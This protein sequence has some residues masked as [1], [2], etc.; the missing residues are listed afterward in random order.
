MGQI[1][2][3][4]A[5]Q[6]PSS[7]RVA[8]TYGVLN[9]LS[10]PAP[11]KPPPPPPR[12][13]GLNPQA[14]SRE[15]VSIP[16]AP[17]LHSDRSHSRSLSGPHSSRSFIDQECPDLNCYL[18][19]YC[20]EGWSRRASGNVTAREYSTS[21]GSGS[22]TSRLRSCEREAQ[23]RGE[24]AARQE[25]QNGVVQAKHQQQSFQE[26]LRSENN[27]DTAGC[28]NADGDVLERALTFTA[29]HGIETD[30]RPSSSGSSAAPTSARE[31]RTW[32]SQSKRD[33]HRAHLVTKAKAQPQKSAQPLP[34]LLP[35]Q[36]GS[37]PQKN[38]TQSSASR[39]CLSARTPCLPPIVEQLGKSSKGNQRASNGRASS[40]PPA[41]AQRSCD[42]EVETPRQ[43]AEE[44]QGSSAG[45]L[46]DEVQEL[47]QGL[48]SYEDDIKAE[49]A[50]AAR[51]KK[52]RER[53]AVAAKAIQASESC[54]AECTELSD[55]VRHLA[56]DIARLNDHHKEQEGLRQ[57]VA[58][59]KVKD[60]R[61]NHQSIV[62]D[63]KRQLEK[64]Q[65]AGVPV[66]T[67]QAVESTQKHLSE[68]YK[69]RRQVSDLKN[70]MAGLSQNAPDGMDCS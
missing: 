4:P 20:Q 41:S 51:R 47:L 19:P 70:L 7:N 28:C 13:G 15:L 37:I 50:E 35:T 18:K 56:P 42:L 11:R 69:Q 27:T 55:G 67:G 39:N 17:V 52:M 36:R 8:A 43:A 45:Q 32:C 62:R 30:S 54:G 23:A 9:Q 3:P 46:K 65:Q 68:M 33:L 63:V 60:N 49:K 2:D 22:G 12:P 58:N 53:S 64:R 44:G 48:S 26:S 57:L 25:V 5:R 10:Y 29:M 38:H 14:L 40:L 16:A 31:I 61:L 34:P 24:E 6:V 21:A 66:S 59:R 1:E